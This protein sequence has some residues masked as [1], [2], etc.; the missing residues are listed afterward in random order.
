MSNRLSKKRRLARA[1]AHQQ[2]TR[3][4]VVGFIEKELGQPLAPWQK[5]VVKQVL[6]G[7]DEKEQVAENLTKLQ[8]EVNGVPSR[9]KCPECGFSQ[10][11]RKD[12]T[13]SRHDV[14]LGSE[15]QECKGTGQ[16]WQVGHDGGA[17]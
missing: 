1:R 14:F 15:P 12:G 5:D 2:K 17:I 11:V 9:A 10:K 4:S 7:S 6:P 13:M 3:T 16:R 8:A